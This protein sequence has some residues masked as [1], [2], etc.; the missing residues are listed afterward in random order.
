[1]Y[2]HTYT[3]INI[4]L[5]IPILR[6]IYYIYVYIYIYIYI[7]LC[8]E[9]Y[10]KRDKSRPISVIVGILLNRGNMCGVRVPENRPGEFLKSQRD[11]H[12][13]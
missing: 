13:K 7:L 12:D 10:S 11:C 4:S 3:Y 8:Y 2:I 6:I 9:L 1:M 5:Y